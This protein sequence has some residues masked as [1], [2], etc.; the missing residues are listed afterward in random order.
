MEIMATREIWHEILINASASE[1]YQ[2]VTDVKKLA[3]WW[4]TDVRT[5][6][7]R[8]TIGILV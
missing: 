8:Q 7:S 4:T 2:G 3:H 6:R 5:I 1:I